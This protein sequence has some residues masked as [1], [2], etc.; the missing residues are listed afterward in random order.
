MAAIVI[1]LDLAEITEAL[2]RIEAKVDQMVARQQAQTT[3]LR[4][5]MADLTEI[6]TEVTE[7]GTVT[8]SAVLLLGNLSDLIEANATDPAA[9]ASIVADL[10]SSKTELAD[11]IVANTPAVT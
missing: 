2:A 10:R 7:L 11:A 1:P 3:D 5:I 9:L 6:T 4:S 8:D